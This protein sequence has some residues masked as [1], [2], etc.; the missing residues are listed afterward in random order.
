MTLTDRQRTIILESLKHRLEVD[1]EYLDL[2][3][4]DKEQY[5]RDLEELI[6][7]VSTN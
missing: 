7:Q 4:T 2:T 1:L 5:K 6:D 3:E